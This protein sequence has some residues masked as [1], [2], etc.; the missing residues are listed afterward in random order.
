[1][2]KIAYRI[3]EAGF[4]KEKPSY[5]NNENCLRNAI[6]AF[7][8]D[9]HEWHVLAD[10]VGVE[11]KAMIEKYVPQKNIEYVTIKNGPGYPFLHLL[12]KL[13][14]QSDNTDI[15]Y[16]IENDYI[17][18][19]G[20]DVVMQ[21]GFNLGAHYVTLYDHPDKYI[22]ATD[23]G[24]PYIEDGGEITKVFLTKS[25]HWKLTNSTT[26]TFASTVQALKDDYQTII[27]YANN[28]YWNDFQMCLELGNRG[29]T[30]ISCIPGYATHG[31]TKWLT[32]LIDWQKV[33]DDTLN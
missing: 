7:P 4:P 21:E 2:I 26:G 9:K 30:I 11:T 18:C 13:I 28:P 10:S 19:L 20:S 14:N 3:S 27:K 15:I 16:F 23:G 8:L 33:M 22:N 17:H 31:E 1:M 12:N 29:R 6:A 32:P 25:C 24:N 5:V